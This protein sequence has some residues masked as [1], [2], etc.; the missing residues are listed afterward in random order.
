MRLIIPHPGHFSAL[1]EII[2]YKEANHLAD[3]DEVYMAGPPQVMGSGRATLHAALID[4]IR[5]QTEYAHQHGI[6]MNIVMNPSC[7]GGYHLTF[8]GYRLFAWYFNELDKAGVDGVTVAEPYLVELLK[9]YSMETVISCVSHVDSPQ[10]AEFYEALGAD[11]IT[12]DTNINRDFSTLKAIMNAVSCNIRVIVNEGCLYKCP[13]RYAHFNLFSHITAVSST[14]PL[15][16]FGDYYFDKCISI[17]VRDPSQIIRSPWIRPEDLAEYERIGIKDFK[18]SGRANA[19]GWIISCMVAY[20][21]RSYNG[22]LLELLDCP[23][24]LRDAFY[25][26]NMALDGCIKQ[27]QNC[28]KICNE[29]RYCDD[30]TSRVLKIKD[31]KGDRA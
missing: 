15:N 3:V 13:F 19:V 20:S 21:R 26:D 25:V 1:K 6:K 4:D 29:C 30:I 24:E 7:L 23:S 8:E 27:W 12:V 31:K 2:E 17:R 22:N 5:E 9:D 16:T 18:I 14:R 11:G 10:R 28:K